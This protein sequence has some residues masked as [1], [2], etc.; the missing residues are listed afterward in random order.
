MGFKYSG[1]IEETL[2]N[3]SLKISAGDVVGISGPSGSG[4]TTLIDLILGLLEPSTGEIY[5]NGQPL[6]S[7][8]SVW[9]RHVTY[10][11]QTGFLIDGS[12]FENITMGV[13]DRL[14]ENHDLT[15]ILDRVQLADFY[16][17]LPNGIDTL[18]GESGA[19]I[20]GGERQRVSLAR[21][22]FFQ[23]D[24]L[25]MDESTNALDEETERSLLAEL[26]YI[27][28]KG[29]IIIVSHKPSVLEICDYVFRINSGRVTLEA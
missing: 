2:T 29:T 13:K 19:R 20:S 10:L 16:K 23:R 4:K 1:A 11:S 26:E 14:A 18:V 15:P 7:M 3:V 24:I 25:V 8:K 17:G 12:L 27:R 5:L 9:Q 28:G 21:A 6:V 22:L